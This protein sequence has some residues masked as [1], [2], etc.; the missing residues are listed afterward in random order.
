MRPVLVTLIFFANYTNAQV[1]RIE[2]GK[3]VLENPITFNTGSS[4]LTEEGRWHYNL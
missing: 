3:L 2:N 1:P 4:E